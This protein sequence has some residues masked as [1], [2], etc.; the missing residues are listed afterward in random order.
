MPSCL[1]AE[2]EI[3]RPLGVGW[4]RKVLSWN[5]HSVRQLAVFNCR[6][7]TG[8][9]PIFLAIGVMAFTATPWKRRIRAVNRRRRQGQ[10]Q[11]PQI[12][13]SGCGQEQRRHLACLCAAS[14]MLDH[15]GNITEGTK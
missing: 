4:V 14:V 11:A 5:L 9:K 3:F 10:R 12:H 7:E 6:E 1:P 8:M 2:A 15:R 13:Q